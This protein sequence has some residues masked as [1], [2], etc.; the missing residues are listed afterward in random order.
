MNEK[1]GH[2]EKSSDQE[3]FYSLEHYRN[4]ADDTRFS[5]AEKSLCEAAL[6][7][8]EN[9]GIDEDASQAEKHVF[10][11][12]FTS[13]EGLRVGLF[14]SDQANRL[15][16]K[17]LT[18]KEGQLYLAQLEAEKLNRLMTEEAQAKKNWQEKR[19]T[20]EEF[21]KIIGVHVDEK[22]E[23]HTLPLD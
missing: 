19:Q 20:L 15:V 10:H 2:E 4:S 18:S 11:K 5:A 16:Q 23:K 12:I 7:F 6:R 3:I 22:R 9:I 13:L 21:A 14:K 8:I 17:F 1:L